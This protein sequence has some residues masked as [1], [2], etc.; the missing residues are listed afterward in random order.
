MTL[1][2]V[3][4][5]LR[6]GGIS[7][8]AAV[9]GVNGHQISGVSIHMIYAGC[10]YHIAWGDVATWL[11]FIATAT[12]VSFTYYIWQNTRETLKAANKTQQETKALAV[13]QNNAYVGTHHIYLRP[14]PKHPNQVGIEFIIKNFGNT[15]AKD[16]HGII[17]SGANKD[18]LQRMKVEEGADR[19]LLMPGTEARQFTLLPEDEYAKIKAGQLPLFVSVTQTYIGVD[20][21]KY[22]FYSLDEYSSEADDFIMSE[23][24]FGKI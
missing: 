3:T 2:P 9:D 24:T 21:S 4:R 13:A 16:L 5:S 22:R 11:I 12:Y 20:G 8:Q 19:A 7:A 1:V 18:K 6:W 14:N 15:P 10:C 17:L 23:S